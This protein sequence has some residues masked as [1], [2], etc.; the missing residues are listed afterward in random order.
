M[1]PK[2]VISGGK[3]AK[4]RLLL[5]VFINNAL[6]AVSLQPACR[7]IKDNPELVEDLDYNL[8]RR[9]SLQIRGPVEL[10][11]ANA[12]SLSQK[13]KGVKRVQTKK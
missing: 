8:N 11:V 7:C 3:S 9:I 5:A 13:K 1:K 10:V 12:K 4:E 6:E 2:I